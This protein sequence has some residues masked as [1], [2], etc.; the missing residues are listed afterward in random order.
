MPP[1]LKAL[2]LTEP[3]ADLGKIDGVMF[4]GGV[5]EYVYGRE[6][7]DFAGTSNDS[8]F[9]PQSLALFRRGRNNSAPSSDGTLSR[10]SVNGLPSEFSGG[11][12][13]F[14]IA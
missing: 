8:H 12:T 14:D 1:P 7:L 13:A 10:G 4:S 6:Q 5:G 9:I 2:Y 3:I 11:S